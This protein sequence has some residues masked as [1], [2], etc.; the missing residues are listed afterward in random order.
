MC[1]IAPAH[2]GKGG[3]DRGAAHH[4]AI[5]RKMWRVTTVG[6]VAR[7]PNARGQRLGRRGAVGAGDPGHRDRELDPRP[8]E[9]AFIHGACDLFADRADRAEQIAGTPKTSCLARSS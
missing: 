4:L 2:A 1:E 5:T 7:P 3:V 6:R 9:R 8:L